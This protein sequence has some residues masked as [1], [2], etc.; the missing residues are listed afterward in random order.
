[1]D[2][3]IETECGILEERFQNVLCDMKSSFTVWDEFTI[4]AG[5]LHASL[6]TTTVYLSSFLESFQKLAD[7]ATSTRGSTRDIGSAMTRLCLRHRSIDSRL[8]VFTTAIM[9]SLVVPLQERM[10]DWK[11]TVAM[12][13]REHAKEYKRAVQEIRKASTDTQ[14]LQ[15]KVK[16]GKTECRAD[17]NRAV[18]EGND[19]LA[20][21][22]GLQKSSVKAALVEER[23]RLCL[24]ISCLKPVMDEEVAMLTE[25]T[26]IQEILHNLC[27][28][29]GDPEALNSFHDPGTN[30]VRKLPVRQ[31]LGNYVRCYP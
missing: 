23:S 10:D 21:L 11:K 12:L 31:S 30:R 25:V 24:F 28:L 14:R 20:Q 27:M 7:C 16:K 15:K 13:D 3:A 6:K 8:K 17:F 1:M 19:K 9:D 22:H 5:R 2:M 4:K 18:Q 26:H 29:S